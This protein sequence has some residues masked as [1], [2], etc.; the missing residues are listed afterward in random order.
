MAT[1]S[2]R[3]V[4]MKRRMRIFVAAIVIVL[5]RFVITGQVK[6][7]KPVT[8]AA[9]LNPD[10][11]DW[12]NW[13]RTLD[14][15][16][17]SPLKQID[18]RNVTQLQLAW[19]W[20]LKP[21]LSQPNPL[22]ANGMMYVPSPGG[23]VQTLDAATGDLLWEFSPKAAGGDPMRTSV[24]RTLAIYADKVYTATADAR[25]IAIDARTGGVAW[26]LQ[27]ADPKQG[28]SY[29]SGPIVVKGMIVAGITG[30][31]RYKNDVCFISAHDPQTGKEIWRTATV[32]R[33]GEPG[34]DTWGDLPL[35]FRAG[36][37]AW[38]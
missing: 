8:D 22:V 13:R 21:G 20:G 24:M 16:G 11:A 27:V 25:L 26:D 10:P 19:S 35:M 18:T 7:F 17:Y 30:C 5:A 6:D 38:I 37:D 23:G 12:P 29:S 9:L 4:V 31:Q 33:P 28:Y 1:V 2:A 36:S 3:S 34:G 15:W 32:A 14:G